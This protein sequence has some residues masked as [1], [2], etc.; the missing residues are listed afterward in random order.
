[1]EHDKRRTI[2]VFIVEDHALVREMICEYME[3][4]DDFHLAGVA[5]NGAEA[6]SAIG[7]SEADVV[8]IDV[9]LP[10]ISGIELVPQIAGP[11]RPCVM[12]SGHGEAAYVKKAMAAGA[13]G[14]VLKGDPNEILDAIRSVASGE[15]YLSPS[16]RRRF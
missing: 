3:V 11:S 12:Y 5:S 10:D 2:G 6:L 15:T 14:Y 4:E 13:R 8:V 9:S 7:P 16:L 1:M